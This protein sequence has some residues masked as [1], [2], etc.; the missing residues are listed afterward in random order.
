MLG[1]KL[2]IGVFC[3]PPNALADPPAFK[4][5]LTPVPPNTTKAPVLVLVEAVSL[6]KPAILLPATVTDNVLLLFSV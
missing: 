1:V 6:L 5:P 4:L 2:P 3:S